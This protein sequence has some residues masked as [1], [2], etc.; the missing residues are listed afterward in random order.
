MKKIVINIIPIIWM[1]QMFGFF[2]IINLDSLYIAIN[3]FILLAL[4]VFKFIVKNNNYTLFLS[5]IISIYSILFCFI[6]Y[7]LYLFFPP[8]KDDILM[9]F[10]FISIIL[11]N[12]SIP[13]WMLFKSIRIRESK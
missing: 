3:I 9:N 5:A 7:M 11:V 1:I 12:I 10:I 6:T 8:A 2:T 4:Y 13:I